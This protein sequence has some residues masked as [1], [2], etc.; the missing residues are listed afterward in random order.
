VETLER[1]LVGHPF[2]QGMKERHLELSFAPVGHF[3][4]VCGFQPTGSR[5]VLPIVT[6]LPGCITWS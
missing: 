1:I 3:R 5:S 2:F 6:E 4:S